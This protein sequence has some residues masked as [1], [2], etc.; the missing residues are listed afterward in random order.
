MECSSQMVLRQGKKLA[1]REE[2]SGAFIR[3]S[4]PKEERKRDIQEAKKRRTPD[5]TREKISPVVGTEKTDVLRGVSAEAGLIIMCT[6]AD[7]SVR[8]G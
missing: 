5:E 8:N 1:H 3:E 6:N 4:R 7:G 2:A